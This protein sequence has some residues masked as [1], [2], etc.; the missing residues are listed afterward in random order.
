MAESNITET[1]INRLSSATEQGWRAAEP[2]LWRWG[3]GEAGEQA[4]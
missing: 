4:L 3:G 2:D 1:I